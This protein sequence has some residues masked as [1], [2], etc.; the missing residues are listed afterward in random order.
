MVFLDNQSQGSGRYALD[1]LLNLLRIRM[2]Q[3]THK[4]QTLLDSAEEAGGGE[5]ELEGRGDAGK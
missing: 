4:L 5:T 1:H 2:N 3:L